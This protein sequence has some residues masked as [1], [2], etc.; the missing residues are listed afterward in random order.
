MLPQLAGGDEWFIDNEPN[1]AVFKAAWLLACSP[2]LVVCKPIS[3][4]SSASLHIRS[5]GWGPWIYLLCELV[6]SSPAHVPPPHWHWCHR[7]FAPA[8]HPPPE[9]IALPKNQAES[10]PERLGAAAS[11]VLRV[12]K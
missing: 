7:A 4:H 11:L 3:V 6:K 10:L 12:N 8:F 5:S 1:E 9:T 2:Q